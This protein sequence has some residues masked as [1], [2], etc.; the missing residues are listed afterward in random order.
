MHDSIV[1]SSCLFGSYYLFS[2]SLASINRAVLENKIMQ[3]SLIALNSLT[4]GILNGLVL[5]MSGSMVIYSFSLL[6]DKSGN[7]LIKQDY[8]GR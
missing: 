8:T 5:G 4:L 3:P 2:V 1:L 6:L 7:N